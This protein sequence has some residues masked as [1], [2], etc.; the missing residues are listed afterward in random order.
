MIGRVFLLVL[1]TLMGI[2]LDFYYRRDFKKSL[3]S[4]ASFSLLVSFIFL[5]MTLKSVLPIYLI[6]LT[7]IAIGWFALIYYLFSGR[8]IWWLFWM[9]LLTVILFWVLNFI[10]GSRYS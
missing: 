3:I 9:P 5:G 4:F 6:H 2:F 1:V 8:Y 10:E 7:F